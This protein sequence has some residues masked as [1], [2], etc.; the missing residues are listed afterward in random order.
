MDWNTANPDLLAVSY[1]EP[2]PDSQKQGILAFWTLKNPSFP[3]KIFYT[4]NCL[5]C[6]E[7]SKRNPNLIAAGDTQGNISIFD[8][9]RGGDKPIITSRHSS[10]KHT[11]TVW[12]VR[13][14]D[15][16]EKGEVLV[17]ISADGQVI[18]WSMRKG[19][20][21]NTLMTLKAHTSA[22]AGAANGNKEGMIF[23]HTSGLSIDFPANDISTYYAATEDCM[24]HR[25]GVSYNEQYLNSHYGHSGPVYRVRCNPFMPS[26]FATCSYDW[27][28]KI[29]QLRE[30][31]PLNSC[32]PQ[33]LTQ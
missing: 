19:L 12:E 33:D 5:T 25:C 10:G 11:D 13:W 9:K 8:I 16:G 22:K 24:V 30:E 2:E 20:E 7:F 31:D 28:I 15:R 3:E 4:T 18:E 1:G 27:T 14:V 23:I 6:C 26:V 29:W 17:S 21:Y 32:T